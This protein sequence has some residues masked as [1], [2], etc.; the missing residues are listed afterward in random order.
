MA[1]LPLTAREAERQLR[2]GLGALDGANTVSRLQSSADQLRR[3]FSV[4]PNRAEDNIAGELAQLAQ[5]VRQA[6]AAAASGAAG[7][8][9]AAIPLPRWQKN[10]AD[11][12]EQHAA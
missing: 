2:E 11:D 7:Q 1:E 12:R 6:G 9:D 5:Q 4:V 10:G 3:G 8:Q